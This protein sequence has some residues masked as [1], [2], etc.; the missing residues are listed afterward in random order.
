M[1]INPLSDVMIACKSKKLIFVRW[2]LVEIP[3]AE[4]E[5]FHGIIR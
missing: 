4:E 2:Y 1:N 3:K 5:L